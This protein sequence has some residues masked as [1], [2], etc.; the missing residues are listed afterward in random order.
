MA[1]SRKTTAAGNDDEAMEAALKAVN[2][3]TDATEAAKE[4]E[5]TEAAKEAE[6][7]NTA[8]EIEEEDVSPPIDLDD[9]SDQ[10]RTML[11]G[12]LLADVADKD[13]SELGKHFA[14]AQLK[15][16][17]KQHA[18]DVENRANWRASA[19]KQFE[20]ELS[21]LGQLASYIANELAKIN[22]QPERTKRPGHFLSLVPTAVTKDGVTEVTYKLEWT[23]ELREPTESSIKVSTTS[24]DTVKP[25]ASVVAG[26]NGS[27]GSGNR[28]SGSK[29]S[30]V[31]K[32]KTSSRTN[33]GS[34]FIPAI[35][36]HTSRVVYVTTQ[37]AKIQRDMGQN[38]IICYVN[39][40]GSVD[41]LALGDPKPNQVD[42]TKRQEIPSPH[43]SGLVDRLQ[44]L[45]E[46]V[47]TAKWENVRNT[48]FG[49]GY[50]VMVAVDGKTE[51]GAVT[52]LGGWIQAS[53]LIKA[54][55]D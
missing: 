51:D 8:E 21:Q 35:M 42:L 5:A 48:S 4:A 49:T 24:S 44:N 9:L 2:D 33:D 37:G 26:S 47:D 53:E 16:A 40:D 50:N 28:S 19:N 45:R 23:T 34:M 20:S 18:Q 29:S 32:P 17:K 3:A 54:Y 7:A 11:L 22:A 36:K 6:E 10:Q 43:Y 14:N 12:M 52:G 27:R 13:S 39:D 30:E 38:A 25:T 46:L 41:V 31:E 15:A 55:R 1:Q